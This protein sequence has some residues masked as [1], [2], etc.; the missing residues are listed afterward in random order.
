[1]IGYAEIAAERIADPATRHNG[2]PYRDWLEMYAGDEYQKLA[3]DAAAALD[4][5]FGRRGG[6]GRLPALAATFTTAVRLEGDFW[7]MG[8]AAAR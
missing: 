5:Q 2:N 1:M 4:E 7:Q 6:E 3:R 8:L